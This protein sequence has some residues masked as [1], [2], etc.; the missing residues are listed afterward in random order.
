MKLNKKQ[1]EVL[2]ELAFVYYSNGDMR[3]IW[4]GIDGELA[5]DFDI[6]QCEDTTEVM[7]RLCSAFNIK[8]EHE[9][10]AILDKYAPILEDHT[11]FTFK[12]GVL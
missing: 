7:Q 2:I 5:E 1:K 10:L 9:V 8:Y 6:T 4:D 12:P 3:D 11:N